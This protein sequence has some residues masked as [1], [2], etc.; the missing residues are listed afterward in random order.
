[1]ISGTIKS[2]AVDTIFSCIFYGNTLPNLDHGLIIG[3]SKGISLRDSQTASVNHLNIYETLP[4]NIKQLVPN[5]YTKYNYLVIKLA[6]NEIVEIGMPW[7]EES[8]IVIYQSTNAII[9]IPSCDQIAL[10]KIITFINSLGFTNVQ[11]VIQ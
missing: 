11:S 2:L 8:S 7:I 10:N 3:I 1:M 6:N 4:S 9:T 5:D